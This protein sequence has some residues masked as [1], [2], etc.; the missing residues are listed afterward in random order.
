MN[1]TLLLTTPC[2][3]Y[4]T[5]PF[6]D[7][8]TDAMGQRFT[9]GDD[10]FT[11]TSH[12][13]CFGTHLLAQ[14]V[15]WPSVVLEYPRWDDFTREVEKGYPYL[16]IS[17]YPVHMDIVLRMCEHVREAAPATKILLGSY[18]AQAFQAVH[19]QET[20]RRYVDHVVAGE[21]VEFLRR[22][23]GDPVDQP[24]R[25]HVFPK[26]GGTLPWISRHPKG[27][28][29]FLVS[30]LGCS[31]GCDFCSTTAMYGKKRVGMLSAEELFAGITRYVRLFPEVKMVFVIEEDHFRVPGHLLALRELWRAHPELY[32]QV[33]LFTF[34]S[35]DNVARFAEKHGWDAILEA[36]IGTIFLGVESKLA[37]EHGYTKRADADARQ[38]FAKLH[39]IGVR[40]VGAWMCGF[41]WHDLATAREDLSY[42]VSL[43]ST[44]QQLTRVSPL[45]GTPLWEKMRDEGRLADVPWED[46]HFWSGAK[47][48]PRLLPHES[49]N[50]IQEGYDQMYRTWGPSIMRRL[51]VQI[52]GYA[53]CRK[54]GDAAL[55][56]H[57]AGLF[58]RMAARGWVVLPAAE[59]FA[60]NG[61]VRR[62]IR[63]IDER[64]RAILGEPTPAMNALA[65]I[66]EQMAVGARLREV[67]SPTNRHLKEEPYKRYVYDPA[68]RRGDGVPYR[69]EWPGR[70]DPAYQRAMT[71]GRW[72]RKVAW[73]A[74]EAA[75]RA[76]PGKGRPDLDDELLANIRDGGFGFGF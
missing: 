69:T 16:G 67:V 43:G 15:S 21:G 4:P 48:N 76:N 46:V 6:H 64:Y 24:V 2:H 37:G 29:G 39:S 49:L 3:P 61:A 57:R 9:K 53:H 45:P 70:P 63:K 11:V 75:R 42:F 23:L 32:G 71:T 22:L 33:E 31:G 73:L 55:R 54:A 28:I 68:A 56:V 50:L 25:Q 20:Q 19:D 27:T 58:Q 62:R 13:H 44:Y 17:A 18:A 1:R 47:I 35:V 10:L 7:S 34:G 38:V 72:A 8:L 51:D 12:S 40:T 59:R 30:G 14:N 66:V 52:S 65:G 60:P 74:C 36:G 26:A 5:L 41:D